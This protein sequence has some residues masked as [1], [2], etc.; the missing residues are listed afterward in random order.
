MKSMAWFIVS[1]VPFSLHI[2]RGTFDRN[3]NPDA[4]DLCEFIGVP[5][6]L[7]LTVAFIVRTVCAKDM[8]PSWKFAWV[9]ALILLIP[10]GIALPVF[11]YFRIVKPAIA[12]DE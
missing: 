9:A 7:I 2:L 4:I 3:I 8:L 5:L 6:A 10:Y 1:I 11:A 12:A